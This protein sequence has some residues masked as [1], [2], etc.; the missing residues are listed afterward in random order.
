MEME[1]LIKLML[2]GEM[3]AVLSQIEFL[4]SFQTS[5]MIMS[6]IT[7]IVVEMEHLANHAIRNVNVRCLMKKSI[8]S[9]HS[10]FDGR[11]ESCDAITG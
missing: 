2:S 1:L 10:R 8:K 4:F 3:R 9:L 11:N 5:I 7:I 6:I